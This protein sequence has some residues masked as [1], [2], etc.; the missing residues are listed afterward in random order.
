MVPESICSR[1]DLKEEEQNE[2][3]KKRIRKSLKKRT[4]T[5]LRWL[6][7]IWLS[8]N[9]LQLNNKQSKTNKQLSLLMI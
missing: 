4:N 6:D 7:W 2:K 9:L 1:S 5:D 3:S 8:N